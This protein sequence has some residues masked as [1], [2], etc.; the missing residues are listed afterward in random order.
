MSKTKSPAVPVLSPFGSHRP[1]ET[2]K[3]AP[4][5]LRGCNWLYW[6]LL[7]WP[8]LCCCGGGAV[9]T[10]HISRGSLGLC[11]AWGWGHLAL[12]GD[13]E[14]LGPEGCSS[15]GATDRRA[16]TRGT[17]PGLVRPPDSNPLGLTPC[18]PPH[19]A[20]QSLG[21]RDC[22]CPQLP[23]SHCGSPRRLAPHPA[24][25]GAPLLLGCSHLTPLNRDLPSL[26]AE[27]P[28]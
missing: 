5:F 27:R 3:E 22:S 24:C 1:W 9:V 2:K 15:C 4:R 25:S 18:Q 12:L 8:G 17:L 7:G 23:T 14:A 16:V 28:R 6:A 21:C 10:L 20:S 13:T 26:L 19:P 11:G